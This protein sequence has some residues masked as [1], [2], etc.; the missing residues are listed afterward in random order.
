L[1]GLTALL[2][3]FRFPAILFFPGLAEGLLFMVWPNYTNLSINNA[4]AVPKKGQPQNHVRQRQVREALWG[5][6]GGWI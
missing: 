2:P 3:A 1:N 5:A 6:G 4:Q